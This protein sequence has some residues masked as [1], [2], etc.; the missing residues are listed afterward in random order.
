MLRAKQ[1]IVSGIRGLVEE[2]SEKPGEWQRVRSV[3][4][5]CWWTGVECGETAQWIIH[6]QQSG[7]NRRRA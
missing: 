1:A 6:L 5:E 4:E 2:T 7:S 3:A